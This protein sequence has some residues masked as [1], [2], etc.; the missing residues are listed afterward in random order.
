VSSLVGSTPLDDFLNESSTDTG[1]LLV[2]IG[3][4]GSLFG[5]LLATG[6]IAFLAVTHRGRQREVAVILRVVGY[7]GALMLVGAAIEVAGVAAIADLSWV[8]AL[9]YRTGRAAMMR[10]LGG[11]LIVLGAGRSEQTVVLGFVDHRGRIDEARQQ[12]PSDSD[13]L[14]RWLPSSAFCFVGA[15]LGLLSFGSDGHTVSRGPRVIHALVNLAHVSAGSVWFGGIVGLVIVGLL[16]R[17]TRE[18][19]AP[20][21][22]RFSS[23]ATVALIVVW[24]AGSLMTLFVIDGFGDLTGTDWG[25]L[26]LL[27]VAAVGVAAAIGGYNHFVVVPALERSDDADAMVGRARSTVSVEAVV[28]VFVVAVT[29]F[30]TTASTN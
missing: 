12:A 7:A 10:L 13:A 11:L 5:V 6:L 21:V 20:D 3:L 27:K 28:L 22:L 8:D 4:F 9:T 15:A 18:S 24:L 2:R 14:V 29:V 16:R 26:L 1:E 25:R 30:L 19:S 23:I 17:S